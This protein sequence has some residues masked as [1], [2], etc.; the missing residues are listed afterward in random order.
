MLHMAG[1]GPAE[2]DP[3]GGNGP[4]YAIGPLV[5]SYPPLHLQHV[6]AD[7]VGTKRSEARY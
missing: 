2:L 3:G 4:C 6:P 7:L 1:K 5:E